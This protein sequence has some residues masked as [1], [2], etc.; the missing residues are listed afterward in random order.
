MHLHSLVLCI[1]VTPYTTFEWFIKGLVNS[2]ENFTNSRRAKYFVKTN[3]NLTD[4]RT[5]PCWVEFCEVCDC[6]YG[7]L[8]CSLAEHHLYQWLCQYQQQIYPLGEPE[9]RSGKKENNII[10]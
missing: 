8:P 5:L 2:L 9:E 7:V 3:Q 6:H 1:V 4:N 10:K